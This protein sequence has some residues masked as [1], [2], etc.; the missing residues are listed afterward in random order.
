MKRLRTLLAGRGIGGPVAAVV[1]AIAWTA[2]ILV[3]G[4]LSL[5][6]LDGAW[7][8]RSR[9]TDDG[10]LTSAEFEALVATAEEGSGGNGN[11]QGD[12]P[13]ICD[14]AKER[15]KSATGMEDLALDAPSRI[16]VI[17]I[18]SAE[19]LKTCTVYEELRSGEA[20]V[21]VLLTAAMGGIAMLLAAHSGLA[22]RSSE[23]MMS[24]KYAHLHGA[25]LAVVVGLITLAV[26]GWYRFEPHLWL[27]MAPV[28]LVVVRMGGHLL[29]IG[30]SEVGPVHS[31][32]EHLAL[33]R[34][35]KKEAREALLSLSALFSLS[36]ALTAA[37]NAR[38]VATR[39]RG[40]LNLH[41]G[42]IELGGFDATDL[43]LVTAVESFVYAAV[44]AA[45]AA[46]AL[47]RSERQGADFLHRHW[48]ADPKS[49]T[50][51]D[52]MG[53]ADPVQRLVEREESGKRLGLTTQ[54]IQ[55]L[56]N[57]VAILFPIITGASA[58]L[59]GLLG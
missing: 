50:P 37:L 31:A 29:R 3:V 57:S 18:P 52:P 30:S 59:L 58:E 6:D 39:G 19:G 33:V 49:A 10:V 24:S 41:L 25:S 9:A 27:A 7:E 12:Q 13:T 20:G 22:A 2:L 48:R 1:V 42:P 5:A 51:E 32:D 47:V 14:V 53:V 17:E 54:P 36:V 46:P 26:A 11:S 40:T 45:V 8:H 35:R 55:W 38:F 4:S 23:A 56:E 21:S 15:Y 34:A 28:L 44:L 43:Q 16:D